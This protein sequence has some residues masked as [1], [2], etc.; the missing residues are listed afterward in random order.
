MGQL[1]T[2]IDLINI[3]QKTGRGHASPGLIYNADVVLLHGFMGMPWTMRLM[4]RLL[5]NHGF[6]PISPWYESWATPFDRIVE[7]IHTQLSKRDLGRERPVHFVGHSMGGL[8]A[9][10]VVDRLQPALM[11]HMVMIGTPN[12]GSEL[13]DFCAR[14]RLLR[15]ILGRAA[16][17]LVTQRLLPTLDRLSSPSYPVG[18]IAGNRPFLGSL[19]VL[20]RPHD[21]KVSVAST[22][23]SGEAD[24]IILPV[25]HAFMPFDR[26]VQ[27]QTLHFLT[28]GTF[29]HKG[30]D[31]LPSRTTV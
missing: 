9:R 28:S 22:H 8:L 31:T 12:A 5:R 3:N 7:R 27:H 13:A 19:R 4:G 18:V 30:A 26:A 21:G 6:A 10:A 16:A 23:F 15:P 11:G 17:A 1:L 29:Q 25:S 2:D 24:H 14:Q 20:P